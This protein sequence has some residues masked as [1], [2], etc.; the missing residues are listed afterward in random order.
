MQICRNGGIAISFS[1][2]LERKQGNGDDSA[3]NTICLQ[4][5]TGGEIC[6]RRGFWGDW[7]RSSTSSDGFNKA[8]LSFEPNQG[9]GD[10]SAANQLILYNTDTGSRSY[11]TGQPNFWGH[12]LGSQRCPTGERICGLQTRVERTQGRGDD[13]ALNGVILQCC[14]KIKYY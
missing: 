4:C 10:D 12:W 3:L 7:A 14:G 5:S 1:Q 6:S 13:S 2:R 11:T 9:G 8:N